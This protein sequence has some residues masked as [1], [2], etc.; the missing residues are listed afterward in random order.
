VQYTRI[1]AL[2]DSETYGARATHG[3]TYPQL[4][5]ERLATVPTNVPSIVL[6][7]G[8]NGERSWEIVDRGVNYLLGDDW[9]RICLCM[10]GTND[11]KPASDTPV[12]HYLAQ[13]DRLLRVSRATDTILYALEIHAINPIGQPEYD[14]RSIER[15]MTFNSALRDWCEQN[16]VTFIDGLF[17]LFAKNLDLL[18]D[19]I[20]PTNTGND[21][22]ANRVFDFL[23]RPRG[24][25]SAA[26]TG[27]LRVDNERPQVVSITNIHNSTA[28]R[29]SRDNP[30][31]P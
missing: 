26:P 1:L 24:S 29:D 14:A 31:Y 11:S 10:M 9:I 3:R 18:A 15:I 19:G 8:L 16:N 7:R 2:G 30:G 12:E 5:E 6:N 21:L 20:H 22:I 23:G 13:W 4:L 25:V 28:E 27:L 17:N